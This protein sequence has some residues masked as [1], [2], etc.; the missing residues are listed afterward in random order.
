M[1]RGHESVRIHEKK[2]KTGIILITKYSRRF[3]NNS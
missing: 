1:G 2:K 3:L